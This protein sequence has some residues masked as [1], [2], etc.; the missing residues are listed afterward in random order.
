MSDDT[1][2]FN[3]LLKQ[4]IREEFQHELPEQY[5]NILESVDNV[6]DYTEVIGAIALDRGIPI[7]IGEIEKRG[8][9]VFEIGVLWNEMPKLVGCTGTA[10]RLSNKSKDWKRDNWVNENGII[11]KGN[12]AK[13]NG[14]S[15]GEVSIFIPRGYSGRI[16]NASN[17]LK[18]E[19]MNRLLNNLQ[20]NKYDTTIIEVWLDAVTKVSQGF[21]VLALETHNAI[22]NSKLK[23]IQGAFND[24]PFK[25][26]KQ[27]APQLSNMELYFFS[28]RDT[29]IQST[30]Y[31]DFMRHNSLNSNYT[32]ENTNISNNMDSKDNMFNNILKEKIRNKFYNKLPEKYWDLIDSV[33]NPS[34]DREIISK[35]ALDAGIPIVV[36]KIENDYEIGVLWNEM[37]KMVGVKGTD[38][39]IRDKAK[40]WKRDK[41][42]E[43]TELVSYR[44]FKRGCLG[45]T[46]QNIEESNAGSGA[47]SQNIEKLNAWSGATSYIIKSENYN[48][49]LTDAS[50]FLKLDGISELIYTLKRNRYDITI[51]NQWLK[52]LTLVSREF[53]RIA[54]ETHH[55]IMLKQQQ[56]QIKLLQAPPSD[57]IQKEADY[58]ARKKL[59]NKIFSSKPDTTKD[60]GYVYI[61]ATKE[62]LVRI[63]VKIGKANDVQKRKQQHNCSQADNGE[64]L[65][66]LPVWNATLCESIIHKMLK[67]SKILHYSGEFFR[68]PQEVAK[69]TVTSIVN[70]IN[71]MMIDEFPKCVNATKHMYINGDFDIEEVPSDTDIDEDDIDEESPSES[72]KKAVES[73]LRNKKYALLTEDKFKKLLESHFKTAFD[74]ALNMV[75]EEHLFEV[76]QTR[77]RWKISAINT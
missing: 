59:A 49:R 16:T 22:M 68:L 54:L 65:L 11:S 4:K 10:V 62:Q 61:Y 29:I 57:A 50:I 73:L 7:I 77:N 36:N 26:K 75:K 51:L 45:A 8:R 28:L 55:E 34:D 72:I 74:E 48:G 52:T 18:I 17:F 24:I 76:N 12:W 67:R 47:T 31:I 23:L 53:P 46:S 63:L 70:K 14:G 1:K 30:K 15:Q 13:F 19:S 38:K 41:W 60:N 37:P 20:R 56:D 43:N 40:D 64:L 6:I 71:S 44:D 32:K 21:H 2:V 5:W 9:K 25:V 69:D 66:H 58:I 42:V 3:E 27:Y 35:L 33:E 39:Y